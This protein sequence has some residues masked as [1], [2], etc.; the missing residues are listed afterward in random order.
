MCLEVKGHHVYRGFEKLFRKKKNLALGE[1][2][3]GRGKKLREDH[4]QIEPKYIKK[5]EILKEY[6][7]VTGLKAGSN[8]N[9]QKWGL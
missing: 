7:N 8:G 4:G 9:G 6:F 3:G 5:Y 2:S 1:G